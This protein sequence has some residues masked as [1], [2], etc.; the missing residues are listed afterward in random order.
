MEIKIG[1]KQIMMVL[2]ILSW[3]IFVGLCI[4]AGGIIFNTVYA[5]YKPIVAKHFWNGADLSELYTSEKAHFITQTILMCI[6]AVLKA[7]IFYLILKLFYNKKVSIAKP[8]DPNVTGVVFTIAF[9]CLG[10]GLFS[11]WGSEYA[12]WVKSNGIAMPDAELMRIGGADVW[13]FM[14]VTLFVIGQVFK[15]GTELQSEN[16]LTV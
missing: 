11:H 8:F 16:D 12:Q 2:L 10:A 1:T 14:A 9:L 5:L 6:V 4:E 15:K 3:I 13:L 7:L